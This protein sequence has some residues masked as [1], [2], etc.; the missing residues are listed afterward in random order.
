MAKKA[1]KTEKEAVPDDWADRTALMLLPY[2][3]D[4][5]RSGISDGSESDS[6]CQ[7]W[8]ESSPASAPLNGLQKSFKMQRY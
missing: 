4:W 1:S 3:G 5:K 2:S 7:I 6:S 8:I